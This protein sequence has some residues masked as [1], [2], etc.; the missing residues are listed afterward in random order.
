MTEPVTSRGYGLYW[1]IWG[2]LL[3]LTLGMI[4]FDQLA[5][6][7]LLLVLVLVTAMLLKA[8]MIAG[9]FMHLKFERLILVLSV[10]FG[11]LVNGAILFALIAPDG[12]RVL[13]LSGS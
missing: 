10:L 11:L 3:A 12:L 2:I 5:V 1:R 7:R 4:V 13:R 8:A 9:Y 6:P